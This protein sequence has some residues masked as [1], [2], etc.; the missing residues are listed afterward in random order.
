MGH[1]PITAEELWVN[2]LLSASKKNKIKYT[3]PY[4]IKPNVFDLFKPKIDK[5]LTI[6][7]MS[8]KALLENPME[9]ERTTKENH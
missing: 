8:P 7:A 2:D 1:P 3:T 5:F 9:N 4:R 6:A